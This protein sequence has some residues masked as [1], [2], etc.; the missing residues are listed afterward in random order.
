MKLLR[1]ATD[2][3]GAK[4]AFFGMYSGSLYP[5]PRCRALPGTVQQ[6]ELVGLCLI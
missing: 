2:L 3:P 5:S 6:F 4:T 1:T